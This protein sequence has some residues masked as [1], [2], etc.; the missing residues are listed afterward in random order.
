MK[1]HPL[2]KETTARGAV[3]ALGICGWGPQLVWSACKIAQFAPVH[4]PRNRFP[5]F[6][7]RGSVFLITCRRNH[8]TGPQHA[9]LQEVPTPGIGK[10]GSEVTRSWGKKIE[11]Q[12]HHLPTSTRGIR[13]VFLLKDSPLG[14]SPVSPRFQSPPSISYK[15][16]LS[17]HHTPSPF[18]SSLLYLAPRTKGSDTRVLGL[19]GFSW[20]PHAPP[21]CHLSIPFCLRPKPPPGHPVFP[22]PNSHLGIPLWVSGSCLPSSPIG[23]PP[24]T[25]P[26][27]PTFQ[28]LQVPRSPSLLGGR[29]HPLSPQPP[30]GHCPQWGTRSEK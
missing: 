19:R 20:S 16:F 30:A 1:I 29:P 21:C 23:P 4:P 22:P 5:L 8:T 25:L 11:S 7:S 2:L 18:P 26:P 6:P 24:E 13:R 15:P 3:A 12:R 27:P 17:T 28:I 14:A 10:T 9:P